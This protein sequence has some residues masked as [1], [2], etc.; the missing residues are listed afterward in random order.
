MKNRALYRE[1]L[2]KRILLGTVTFFCS[3]LFAN[4][5]TIYVNKNATGANNGSNWADAYTDLQSALTASVAGDEIWVAEGTYYPTSGTDRTLSF[6]LK[7][8]VKIYGGFGGNETLLTQRNWLTNVTILNGD[9]GTSADTSDN[10]YHVVLSSSVS[11]ATEL[12]GFTITNGCADGSSGLDN[13]GGGMINMSYSSPTLSHLVF[14]NNCASNVAGGM[15]NSYS[16][17]VIDDIRFTSNRAVSGGGGM[18]MLMATSAISNCTFTQNSASEGGG[19]FNFGNGCTYIDCTFDLNSATHAAGMM[20]LFTSAQITN[21]TFTS[22]SARYNGGGIQNQSGGASVITG[23]TFSTNTANRGAGIDNSGSS[24]SISNTLFDSNV[25]VDNGGGMHCMGSGPALT[26][27]IFRSNRSGYSG[28]GVYVSSGSSVLT[29]VKFIG[30]SAPNYG[31]GGMY[32]YSGS[33]RLSEVVFDSNTAYISGGLYTVDANDTLTNCIFSKNETTLYGTAIYAGGSAGSIL[34]ANCDVVGNR[35]S[36]ASGVGSAF[37]ADGG[38]AVTINN[39]VFYDNLY[40]NPAVTSSDLDY[41]GTTVIN[42][43][44][45]ASN[46]QCNNC[47]WYG[48]N[49]FFINQADGDGADNIWATPDDGL[50][51]CGGSPLLDGGN[52]SLRGAST[53]DITGTM[54]QGNVDI[55]AYEGG[56]PFPGAAIVAQASDAA[57]CAGNNASFSITANGA[58]SYVWQVRNNS[59]SSWTTVSGG[60]YSGE[61]TN[62][63]DLT[64]VGAGYNGSQYRCYITADCGPA[65]TSQVVTLSVGSNILYVDAT[66]TGSN[67]GSSWANAFTDLQP[68]LLLAGSC[69]DSI[70]VATGTYYPTAGTDRTISFN[71]VEGVKLVG[72]YPAGGGTR[73]WELNTTVL[74]GD[75][76]VQGDDSDNSLNVVYS[77]MQTDATGIDGFII[78]KGFA[79]INVASFPHFV[80]GGMSIYV[81]SP[82]LNNLSFVANTS[83]QSGGALSLY[84]SRSSLSNL[85]FY[86]NSCT[87]FGGAL[88]L[89]GYS[90]HADGLVFENNHSDGYGGAISVRAMDTLFLSNTTLRSNNGTTGHGIYSEGSTFIGLKLLFEANSGNSTAMLYNSGPKLDL[91]DVVFNANTT[92]G[93]GAGLQV[94]GDSAVIRNSVFTKNIAS[95]YGGAMRLDGNGHT[96]IINCTFEGNHINGGPDGAAILIYGPSATIQNS[97][98]ANNSFGP[99]NTTNVDGAD[100]FN[101]MG[102]PVTYENSIMQSTTTCTTCPAPNTDPLFVNAVNPV[103]IDSIWGTSDDGLRFCVSSAAIDAGDNNFIAG[104]LTDITGAARIQNT[105]VDMGAYEGGVTGLQVTVSTQPAVASACPGSATSFTTIAANAAA[106]QW[107]LSTDN[108]ATWTDIAGGIYSNETTATLS[109]NG[110]SATE[111]GNQYRCVVTGGPCGGVD[112]TNAVVLTINAMPIVTVTQNEI[113]LTSDA[114]PASYQWLDCDNS[115]TAISG[116]ISQVFTATV[117]GNYAV[118]VTQNGCVDTSACVAVTA[119]GLAQRSAVNEFNVYP[120]PAVSEIN[121]LIDAKASETVVLLITDAQGKEVLNTTLTLVTGRNTSNYK[122]DTYARGIYFVEVIGKDNVLVKKIVLN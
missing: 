84:Y 68:A 69:T 2:W 53:V 80:G 86:N 59:N 17:P 22:N 58:T 21:C 100:V 63:L 55:G 11:A 57:I 78:T 99:S 82:A 18:Y 72:G 95:D 44:F 71:L 36:F 112:T 37:F 74:N 97:I 101:Y 38:I 32:S 51:F 25:S 41:S 8:Q 4:A 90:V 65:D 66:A 75:I 56:S 40:G 20:N 118:M 43:S 62:T 114:T 87:Y 50:R 14:I 29:R 115:S 83:N 103:G 105:T 60:I 54:H 120:N 79:D 106:Y 61:T 19:A 23:C 6:E 91:A 12:N 64:S 30:N 52:N 7:D 10:S 15:F 45:I 104:T 16:S 46:F 5:T 49:P 26:D 48:G 92:N 13:S 113:V 81:S 31:G 107:Q 117:N 110:P 34:V 9:L 39:S 121:I 88:T 73:D 67:D 109:V 47:P 28:G 35:S 94:N 1:M 108:G 85:S 42:N 116:E 111:N 93:Y 98:F 33:V 3:I 119:V 122:A 89:Y 96:D 70:K 24:P 77:F 27:C 102:T 76:G